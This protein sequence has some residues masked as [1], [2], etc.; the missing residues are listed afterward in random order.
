[1]IIL[2]KESIGDLIKNTDSSKISDIYFTNDLK[3]AY[4]RWY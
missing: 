4:S 3:N 1:M 2:L